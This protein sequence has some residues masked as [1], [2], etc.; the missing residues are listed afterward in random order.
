MNVKT[1]SKNSMGQNVYLVWDEGVKEGVLID[2]GA[3]EADTNAIM[4]AIQGEDVTV[5]AILLTHGHYDHIIGLE[6]LKNLTGAKVYCHAS[7]KNMLADPEINLSSR[8]KQKIAAAPDETLNDGDTIAVGQSVLKA[9]HTPGHTPGGVCFYDAEGGNLFAG[10]TLFA[11]SVGRTDL[12][13][14]DP[15]KLIRNIAVKLLPLPEDTVVYPGHGGATTIGRE[16]KA[17]PFLK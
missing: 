4:E 2:A 11:G 8:I 1:F 7:E 5:K 9:L 14:G 16:K 10:D 13:A 3:N 15:A 6:G 12:P 17:N